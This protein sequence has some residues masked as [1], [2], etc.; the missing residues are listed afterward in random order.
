MNI[1]CPR[2]Q[3][4]GEGD[5]KIWI[6]DEPFP[7]ILGT[8]TAAFFGNVAGLRPIRMPLHGATRVAPVG[9]NS[10]YRWLLPDAITFN[11][12]LRF[13]LENWQTDQ[14]DDVYYNSVAYWYGQPGA[15]TA[16]KALSP[17]MLE[18]AGIRIPGAVE[19]EG[20]IIG[21]DWGHV[22]KD[23]YAGKFEFSGQ[24][25]AI[26]TTRTPVQVFLTG[27]TPGKYHLNL[28]VETGRSFGTVTVRDAAG[29]QIGVVNYDRNSDGTYP[30][31][32]ITLTS[33]KTNV[34][35]QCSRT[36]IL[37]CWVLEKVD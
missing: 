28:R 17:E 36:T 16:F 8:S 20:N 13:T 34:L 18:L 10:V 25:G 30:V 29:Q 9:K 21:D 14:A 4:W 6:D 2:E 1:D 33:D 32:E 22:K 23:K 24:A 7:S 35:V 26:I 11:T 15:A 5:H 37:D 31:G 19:I 12:S 3:W 27:T